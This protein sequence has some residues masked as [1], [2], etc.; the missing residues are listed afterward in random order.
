MFIFICPG[1]NFYLNRPGITASTFAT[2]MFVAGILDVVSTTSPLLLPLFLHLH[3]WF[4]SCMHHVPIFSHIFRW[5][6]WWPRGS[7]GQLCVNFAA[8]CIWTG[9][10]F[11][12]DPVNDYVMIRNPYLPQFILVLINPHTLSNIM[13]IQCLVKPASSQH[14]RRGSDHC[15]DH[16]PRRAHVQGVQGARE[17]SWE[18]PAAFCLGLLV[19][20]PFQK[21]CRK[22]IKI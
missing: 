3:R 16:C 8:A 13:I 10:S 9:F 19:L 11:L 6:L 15:A 17:P 21:R 12:S 5:T 2:G 1:S 14:D 22:Y 4:E 7:M 20:P 18:Q